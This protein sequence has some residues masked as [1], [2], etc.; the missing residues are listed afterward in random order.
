MRILQSA[1]LRAICTLLVGV[2]MLIYPVETGKWASIVIGC[3]FIIPGVSSVISYYRHCNDKAPENHR[4]MFPLAGWGSIL[5]GIAIL[6]LRSQTEQTAFILM[7]V[8]LVILAI[9]TLINLVMSR[10]YYNI[11]VGNFIIPVLV[12]IIGAVVAL[13][14]GEIQDKLLEPKQILEVI[15]VAFILYGVAELYLSIRITIG[16]RK[17]QKQ[18]AAEEKAREE[19][20]LEAQQRAILEA[21]EA[22][23]AEQKAE[24]EETPADSEPATEPITSD[25]VAEPEEDRLGSAFCTS[26]TKDN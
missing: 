19:A 18:L 1:I 11:G 5:L 4:P 22:A 25:E 20:E 21:E 13:F 23:P 3:L 26:S 8:L 9:S 16:R 14:S 10:K 7:G 2:L 24:A 15:A 12:L 17:Y 6:V